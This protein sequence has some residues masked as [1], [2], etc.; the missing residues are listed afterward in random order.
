MKSNYIIDTEESPG[1]KNIKN[2]KQIM[3]NCARVVHQNEPMVEM[4]QC[5]GMAAHSRVHY[6][7]Y[8]VHNGGM[9][10]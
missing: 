1:V 7:K 2:T 8:T 10:L 3:Q 4:N 6:E 9:F 5:G